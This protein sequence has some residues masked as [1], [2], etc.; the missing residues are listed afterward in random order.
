MTAGGV[1]LWAAGSVLPSPPLSTDPARL[2]S[3]WRAVDPAVAAMAL[4]RLA[5]I[6]VGGYLVLTA[7]VG[8]T[9]RLCRRP[10]WVAAADRFTAPALRG[11]LDAAVGAALVAATAT[12]TLPVVA[13][14]FP[15]AGPGPLAVGAAA[16]LH[17][18]RLADDP[19]PVGS[20]GPVHLRR[21]PDDPGAPAPP[22]G[23]SGP[24][25]APAEPAPP[26]A[27]GARRPVEPAPVG[28]V[29]RTTRPAPGAK[30]SVP[31]ARRTARA[32]PLAAGAG[33]SY[34]VRPGD[35][36]WSI[37]ERV[38]AGRLG[39]RPTD[40]ETGRYWQTLVAANRHR[41][42]NPDLIFPGQVVDLPG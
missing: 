17:L 22:S 18:R 10:H 6:A 25:R 29:H 33:G 28:P 34:A 35:S 15:N 23:P 39:R 32:Q 1:L 3:W 27:P 38:E 5:A 36:F 30:V 26:A 13:E 14:A 24:I 11:L 40:A 41:V 37:A 21:L 20:P 4:V 31:P 9:V 19:G 2:N 7:V 8:L 42:S 16:P 12:T